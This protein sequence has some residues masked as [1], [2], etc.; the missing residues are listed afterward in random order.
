[1]DPESKLDAVR[2]IGVRTGKIAAIPAAALTGKRIIDGKGLVAA[3]GFID[4]HAH[5]QE[6]E[7]QQ[8]QA[9]DGVQR[10]SN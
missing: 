9:R 7:N 3:P 2:S 1:M 6:L 8:R 5:G 10:H 4:L